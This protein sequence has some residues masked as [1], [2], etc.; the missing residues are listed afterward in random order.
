MI[1]R[2]LFVASLVVCV[3]S[4]TVTR[5]ADL[6]HGD[7]PG[8]SPTKQ[9]VGEGAFS[10]L[11]LPARV[12]TTP[13]YAWGL[14]GY[15]SSRKKAIFDTMAEVHLWG[16]IALRVEAVY[17]QDT[18]RMRPSG[19]ARVQ[20]LNQE[21]HGLDGALSVFFKT[22]GFTESEG[23]IET[24]ASLGRRFEVVSVVGNLVYGQDPE[25]NERDGEVRATV[26][27][28]TGRFSFGADARARFAIGTQHGKAA[29]VEPKFDALGGPM[30]TVTVGPFAFF[31]EAG[32]SAFSLGGT[33]R[34]GVGGFGG[35]GS[36]F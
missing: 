16:P 29:T 7:G 35:L 20:L 4:P 23:E 24:Y 1:R 21:K 5:A 22:E 31:A 30:A 9:A 18:Q 26:F 17:S 34:V 11:T 6:D 8:E 28:Q 3:G 14:G 15:D 36:T 13:A 25:G 10:A 2:G 27:H 12:G 33:T 19:G 32:P